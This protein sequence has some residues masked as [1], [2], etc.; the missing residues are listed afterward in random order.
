MNIYYCCCVNRE[1]VKSKNLL[2]MIPRL[3]LIFKYSRNFA[4]VLVAIVSKVT[5]L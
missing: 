3:L 2:N 5:N 4:I 1:E